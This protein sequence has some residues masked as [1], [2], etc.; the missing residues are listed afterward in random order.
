MKLNNWYNKH[1]YVGCIKNMDLGKLN[2][3][4]CMS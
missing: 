3:V 2:D 1:F 4:K